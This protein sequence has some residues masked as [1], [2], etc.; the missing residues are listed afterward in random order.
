MAPRARRW[1]LGLVVL[2]LLLVPA[3]S[4]PE[5][6]PR[7]GIGFSP[8]RWMPH[9][10]ALDP[11][12]IWADGFGD[13][14]GIAVDGQGNVFVADRARGSVTRIA[15]DG[16]RTRVAS[17]LDRPVGLA[18]D[19][20]GR[21]LIAEEKAGRVVR[22]EPS[23][24]PTVLVSRIKQPRWLATL[25]DGTLFLSARRL[26]RDTDPEPDDESAE[27][28]VILQ[29]TPTGQLRVFADGFKHLQGLVAT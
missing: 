21:L 16:T 24:R 14:R 4:A 8:A 26:T 29:L 6:P 25:P 3:S 15:P 20:L 28:E 2:A 27:P 9:L 23:G 13:L 22:L 18:F 10:A 5:S 1:P 19:P 7:F 17:G 12:E 11:V